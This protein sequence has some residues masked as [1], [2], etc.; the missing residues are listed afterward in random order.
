MTKN[1][2]DD[3][4]LVNNEKNGSR[5]VRE[6][7]AAEMKKPLPEIMQSLGEDA[8]KITTG[9][10]SPKIKGKL[11]HDLVEDHVDGLIHKLKFHL[12]YREEYVHR[13]D[14]EKR[15]NEMYKGAIED[16]IDK[17]GRCSRSR[18]MLR[19]Q[20]PEEMTDKKQLGWDDMEDE[21]KEELEVYVKDALGLKFGLDDVIK[22]RLRLEDRIVRNLNEELEAHRRE[23]SAHQQ[24]AARH[25]AEVKRHSTAIKYITD[26]LRDAEE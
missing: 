5:S 16:T 24:E 8:K 14:E 17:Y 19:D 7:V 2:T 4:M 22:R 20:K 1:H 6:R 12:F 26:M 15:W 10:H 3:F 25:E 11:L 18:K 23:L 13:I 9:T 21:Q